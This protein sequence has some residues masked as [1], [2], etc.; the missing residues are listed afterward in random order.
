[1]NIVNLDTILEKLNEKKEDYNLCTNCRYW[2]SDLLIDDVGDFCIKFSDFRRSISY[3][4][5]DMRMVTGTFCSSIRK[6][7]KLFAHFEPRK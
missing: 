5:E 3:I 6:N 1:M 4:R 2:Y 7:E